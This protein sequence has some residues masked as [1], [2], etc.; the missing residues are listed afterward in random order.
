MALLQPPISSYNKASQKMWFTYSTSSNEFQHGLLGITDS[1]IVG[2][3]CLQFPES[4]PLKAKQIEV[5][6][7]G[8]EYVG[9]RCDSY[10]YEKKI[11]NQSLLLWESYILEKDP[12]EEITKANYPFQFLLPNDLPQSINLGTGHIYYKVKARIN[13]KS[14]FKKLHGSE[15]KIECKCLITRYSPLPRP[16]PVQWIEWD[17]PNALNRGL[18]YYISMDYD[19]FG[20]EHPIIVKLV[21]KLLRMDLNVKEIFIGLKEYHLFRVGNV[22]KGSK[23]YVQQKSIFGDQLRTMLID[24]LPHSHKIDLHSC[25]VNWTTKRPNINV[26]HQVEIK[27]KF[28]LFGPIDINL[29]R[30][31]N[32]ANISNL[33]EIYQ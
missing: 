2:N 20:P 10:T 5:I 24:A 27:I 16:A 29:K 31:V 1:Y 21:V 32:I 3:L 33:T 28:G 4:E 23:R 15:K 7:E 19:T 22:E 14:N 18:S 17:D 25:N 11:L 30:E 13:R 26:C 6:L 12:Y 9:V 8:I